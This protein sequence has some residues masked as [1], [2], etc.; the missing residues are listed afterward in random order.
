MTAVRLAALPSSRLA[1]IVR[2]Q[3]GTTSSA[4]APR[5]PGAA[6]ELAM[7]T[8][9]VMTPVRPTSGRRSSKGPLL[10]ALLAD[11]EGERRGG[12]EGTDRGVEG[13]QAEEREHAAADPAARSAARSAALVSGASCSKAG[14]AVMPAPFVDRRLALVDARPEAPQ[15]ADQPE[16]ATN[17]ITSAWMKN[18]R[19]SGMP[20]LTCISRRRF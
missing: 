2:T 20:V 3:T 5:E 1:M 13:E 19:S 11:P 16:A 14:A 18:R 9:P 6:D 12:P 17:M 8:A 10:A 7:A 15:G 4:C